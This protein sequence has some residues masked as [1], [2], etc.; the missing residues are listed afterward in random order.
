VDV[1]PALWAVVAGV[2]LAFGTFWVLQ[3]LGPAERR[4][5]HRRG[6][7]TDKK[8]AFR[9][10]EAVQVEISDFGHVVQ[11]VEQHGRRAGTESGGDLAF[12]FTLA[13]CGFLV[14][15]AAGLGVGALPVLLL[16]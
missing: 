3:A 11:A 7:G 15:T 2:A 9:E 4:G 16:F 1:R 5:S 13:G 12:W 14:G 6:A 8:L 10:G